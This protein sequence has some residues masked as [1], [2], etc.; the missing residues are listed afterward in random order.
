MNMDKKA[1]A[2]VALIMLS[3]LTLAY[4]TASFARDPVAD[5]TKE[6]ICACGCGKVTYDCYC[7]LAKEWK[8]QITQDVAAGKTQ[9]QIIASYVETYG[10][11]VLATPKKS[12][13]ELSI[14][15]L[16]VIAAVF[17][18]AVI[19][20]YAKKKSPIPDSE[21]DSRIL[22]PGNSRK[23]RKK[24][25]SSKSAEHYDNLLRKEYKKQKKKKR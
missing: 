4:G 25:K 21:V 19:Y 2:F 1:S 12:G 20:T 3:S 23:K 9:Q 7:D 6:L 8:D 15:T 24:S 13:L 17:G 10:D 11:S 5:I 16:P 22:E 18:T 14:W